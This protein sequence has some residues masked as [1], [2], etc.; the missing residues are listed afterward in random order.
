[1]TPHE[2][3][4]FETASKAAGCEITAESELGQRLLGLN[5]TIKA[6]GGAGGLSSYQIIGL[7]VTTWGTK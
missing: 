6:C 3:W 4:I 5:E 2:K 7:A 1:M